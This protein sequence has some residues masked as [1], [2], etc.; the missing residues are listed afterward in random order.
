MISR[1]PQ[2]L[3]IPYTTLFRSMVVVTHEMGFARKAGDR[4]L[5]MSQGKIAEDTTPEQFITDPQLSRAQDFLSKI[6]RKS[7]RL[8]SS[9]VAISYAVLCFYNKSL[10]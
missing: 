1:A 2:P 9:H 10:M 4:L 6:D 7:T 3:R 5:F 8:N